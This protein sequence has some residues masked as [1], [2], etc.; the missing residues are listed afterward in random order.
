MGDLRISQML[1]G[2]LE[3]MD[4]FSQAR[5]VYNQRQ[6]IQSDDTLMGNPLFNPNQQ[7][8][9]QPEGPT[10]A[11]EPKSA[12]LIGSLNSAPVTDF[13][14]S[15]IPKMLQKLGVDDKGIPLNQ[16]G[17]IQLV[18]RLQNRFGDYQKNTDVMDVLSTFDDTMKKFPMDSQNTLN[19]INSSGQRTLKA[20]LGGG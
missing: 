19:K 14:S 6:Q 12:S 17:R 11:E 10:M 5:E 13:A 20:V 9:I 7:Q 3:R 15:G 2:Q 16:L 8:M 4:P 18:S 1:N